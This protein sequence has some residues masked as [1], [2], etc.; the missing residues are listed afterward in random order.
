LG[1]VGKLSWLVS[2]IAGFVPPLVAKYQKKEQTD[3]DEVLQ[4]IQIKD[5][6]NLCLI[7][8]SLY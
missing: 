1:G 2:K 8:T 5:L 6:N 7:L 4:Q 3:K